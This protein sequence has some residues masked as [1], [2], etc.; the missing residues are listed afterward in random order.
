MHHTAP[1]DP[2]CTPLVILAEGHL[3]GQNIKIVNALLRYGSWP[4]VA[5]IDSTAAGRTTE[6]I[7]GFGPP[8]P[9]VATI[10]EAMKYGPE[11]LII[12]IATQGGDL[13]SEWHSIIMNALDQG[14][15]IINGLHYML[16]EDS[17]IEKKAR[18]KGCILWDVR[19]PSG[20]FRVAKL[21]SRP[22]KPRVILTVGSDCSCGKMY[23]TLE[24]ARTLPHSKFLATGQ[25]GILIAGTGIPL[26][27][28]IADFMAGAVEQ[29]VHENIDDETDW[30]LVEG[31]GSLIHPSFSGVTLALM[32]GSAP[33][34]MILCHNAN[35]TTLKNFSIPF[36]S[37]DRLIE[38]YE[39]SAAFVKPAK[40]LGI[41]INCSGFNHA[42]TEYIL[43]EAE[44]LTGL[45][46]VDP[47][48]T[49]VEKLNES[50]LRYY[51]VYQATV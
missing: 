28:Y 45:P 22:D 47:V 35:R 41:S 51:D 25:T 24:L 7:L 27:R 34:A 13:P 18:E 4:I 5:A 9:V 20:P 3:S 39:Q 10:E 50:I 42:D 14:L 30:L 17:L 43:K 1:L 19:K 31:Q 6:E 38:I 36:P 2:A 12:G 32:H 26:D 21:L 15:H 48:K 40:I 33:D 46:A 16:S 49:G 11:A 44:D 8:V 23:T 37:L 29:L